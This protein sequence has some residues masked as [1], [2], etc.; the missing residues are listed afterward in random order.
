MQMCSLD[1]AT[2]VLIVNSLDGIEH[3]DKIETNWEDLR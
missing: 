1:V 3:K 2:L